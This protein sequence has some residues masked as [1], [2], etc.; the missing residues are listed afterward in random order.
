MTTNTDR[1]ATLAV[2]R[3]MA[4]QRHTSRRREDRR[5]GYEAATGLPSSQTLTWLPDRWMRSWRASGR[6]SS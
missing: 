3:D 4:A 2:I 6:A 5:V 1:D